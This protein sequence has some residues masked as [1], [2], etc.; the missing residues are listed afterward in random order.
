MRNSFKILFY[1]KKKQPL[2]SGNY[3]I[4]C[5]ITINGLACVFSTNLTVKPSKWDNVQKRVIGR[6]KEALR[7]NRILDEIRFSIYETYMKLHRDSEQVTPQAVRSAYL[8]VSEEADGLISFFKQYNREF[9][10]M[11]GITRSQSTLYKYRYVCNHLQ[12]FISEQ[13]HLPDMPLN[14]VNIDFIRDFH[15]W[16]INNARC[17]VNTTWLYMIAFKH[18]ISLATSRGVITVNPFLGYRLRSEQTHRNFLL[19]NEIKRL[20]KVEVNN[21]TETLVRDAFIFSCFTGLSYSDIKI[22]RISDILGEGRDMYIAMQR[23]KTHTPLNIPLTPIP[24]ELIKRHRSAN[25]QSPIFPLP[26]N[27]WCNII[28]KR[29][30]ERTTISKHIT[31]HCSRHTFATTITLSEGVPIEVV[32]SML[33]HTNIK[34]TQTYAKVLQTTINAEM[35]RATRS[36]SSYFRIS[37]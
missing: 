22:L 15:R 6:S 27:Y 20:M 21:H 36:L 13:Y 7:T 9:N 14:K 28:L 33:G 23:I 5:R 25:S 29:L 1:T 24:A 34:T 4:L 10:K 32:S 16:L 35:Q 12:N 31:F 30:V 3:P 19:K 8:G 2:R 37:S 17:S 11:V 18:I 26:S